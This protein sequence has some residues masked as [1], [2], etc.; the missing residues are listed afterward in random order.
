VVNDHL[1]A[2]FVYFAHIERKI[3]ALRKPIVVGINGVD[4]SGKTVFAHGLEKYPL[5]PRVKDIP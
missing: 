2:C 5:Y 4:A 1:K 3:S